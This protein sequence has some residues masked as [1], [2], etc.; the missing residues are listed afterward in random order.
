[1]K[2]TKILTVVMALVICLGGGLPAFPESQGEPIVVRGVEYPS[3]SDYFNSDHF[4]NIGGRCGTPDPREFPA[5]DMA[6]G[7]PADCTMNSTTINSDY[8]PG[9]VFLIPVVVHVISNTSGTGNISDLMVQSQIDILNEDFEALIGTPGEYGTNTAIRFVLADTDPGGQPTNGIDRVQNNS[10]YA[11]A[12][13][14]VTMKTALSWDTTRYLNLYT[15][16]GDGLLGWATFPQQ[17]AGQAHDGVVVLWSA[18]GRNSPASPYNQG[19]T[20]THE[21]GH[22]LGLFHPFQSGCGSAA[23]CY[24]TADLICDTPPDG[25]QTFNCV[26]G[27]SCGSYPIPIENYMEYTNDTCMELFTPEQGNRMR[28]SAVNYRPSLYTEV[29]DIDIFIDGFEVGDTTEWS[30]TIPQP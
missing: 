4:K 28:C 25:N 2:E 29:A 7:V 26:P 15:T 17:T 5:S 12:Y 8:E 30:N 21:I 24:T 22:Y 14:C 19:R 9:P 13:P 18:F 20:A 6:E 3:Q 11:C 23:A 1:M 16:D 27:T 10:Y